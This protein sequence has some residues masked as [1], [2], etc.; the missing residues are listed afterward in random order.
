M[1]H[2]P[3]RP[4]LLALPLLLIFQWGQASLSFGEESP[5]RLVAD[6]IQEPK[7]VRAR[8]FGADVSV[9]QSQVLFV[10]RDSI[11]GTL[12]WRSDGSQEGTIPLME[13]C[14]NPCGLRSYAL[15]PAAADRAILIRQDQIWVT[16]GRPEGTRL[17]VRL[18]FP[19]GGTFLVN[20]LAIDSEGERWILS[21]SGTN[22]SV[23]GSLW[24]TDGTAEGT[25]SLPLPEGANPYGL[26]KTTD[27]FFFRTSNESGEELLWRTDGTAAGT[28]VVRDGC[29]GSC[30]E[31]ASVGLGDQLISVVRAGSEAEVWVS[32]GTEAGTRLLQVFDAVPSN[33]P[34]QVFDQKVYGRVISAGQDTLWV[35]DGSVGGTRLAP[36][37]LPPASIS[38]FRG[39]HSTDHAL[40]AVFDVSADS[41]ESQSELWALLGPEGRQKLAEH[42]TIFVQGVG[43]EALFFSRSTSE[44][45]P[46]ERSF[47]TTQGT[48][49]TTTAAPL[50]AQGIHSFGDQVLL[51]QIVDNPEPDALWF[52]PADLSAAPRSTFLS[53]SDAGSNPE[54]P[55]PWGERLAVT[56]HPSDSLHSSSDAD[57][58]LLGA[59]S[60]HLVSSGDVGP[61][62]GTT[63]YLYQAAPA[64]EGLNVFAPGSLSSTSIHLG[65]APLRLESA[66]DRLF[67]LSEQD[68]QV[69]KTDGSQESTELLASIH[70]GWQG[71]SGPSPGIPGA[72]DGRSLALASLPDRVLVSAFQDADGPGELWSSDGSSVGTRQIEVFPV[73]GPGFGSTPSQMTP[74]GSKVFFVASDAEGRRQVWGTDG[75][76]FAA[77]PLTTFSGALP[78]SLSAWGSGVIFHTFG[79]SGEIWRL[80]DSEAVPELVARLDKLIGE[81]VVSGDRVFVT[82]FDL[83]VGRELWVVDG[84]DQRV[85]DIFPGGGS[86]E[87]RN[88][89]PIPGGI[90]FSADDGSGQGFEPWISAGT[91]ETTR[92]LADLFPG[93]ESSDP[94]NPVVVGDTLYFS[95]RAPDIGREL[96]ALDLEGLSFDSCPEDRLCLQDGRF[97]VQLRWRTDD[98]S[99]AA[100]RVASTNDSGLFSFFEPDNWEAMVKVLDGCS[101]NGQF[102]VFAATATNL[103]YTLT[104]EDTST[105]AVRT[106]TNPPASSASAVTDTEAFDGC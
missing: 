79:S 7:E 103:G 17:V 98:R 87:L 37:L 45:F 66:S 30:R 10:A 75:E 78:T 41:S 44:P 80:A 52:Q 55:I 81:M 36:E 76:P 100:Q 96:F 24:V 91:A 67:V 46:G 19:I 58:W 21:F 39:L 3:I 74:V 70:P 95:A 29:E 65:V 94:Q 2:Q 43:T 48:P 97:E 40:Y 23:P 90:F 69:W 25:R 68:Q 28:R 88:L 85:I 57:L 12:L 60:T 13:I 27:L 72:G 50:G 16:D 14:P 4:W 1:T 18:P 73:P 101:V 31:V 106:Y 104:V 34:L 86:S 32:D 99:G 63:D 83:E 42:E 92:V 61:I 105:G 53:F 51:T 62:H 8:Y 35:S 89:T 33:G 5:I 49:Q 26:A 22:S 64:A 71:S 15:L 59:E 47:W 38:F 93:H 54:A 84:P 102:W 20:G 11:T 9:A 6:L 82:A 56:A 77:R